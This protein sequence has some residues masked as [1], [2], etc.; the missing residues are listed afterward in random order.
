[1]LNIERAIQQKFPNFETK[2]SWIKKPTFNL[3]RKVTH[4]QEI[5]QFLVYT[6]RSCRIRPY[7]SGA[8]AF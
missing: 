1:M 6:P 3:L 7:R 8:G 4:Q 5:N 2:S